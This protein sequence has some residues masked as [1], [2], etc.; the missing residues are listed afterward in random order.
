MSQSG[1]PPPL[2]PAPPFRVRVPRSWF[3]FLSFT[4]APEGILQ[5]GVGKGIG[6][7]QDP[8][9]PDFLIYGV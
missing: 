2:S 3:F 5:T 7:G 1:N 4:E 6:G 8:D 9:L